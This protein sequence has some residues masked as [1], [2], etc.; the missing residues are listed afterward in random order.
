[1]KDRYLGF[2]VALLFPLLL[3]GCGGNIG[4]PGSTGSSDTGIVVQSVTPIVSTPTSTG[5]AASAATSDPD[6]DTAIHI[7]NSGQPE[8]GLFQTF[9]SLDV[10]TAALN[11]NTTSDPFPGSIEECTITYKKADENP[12]API[13]PQLTVYPNCP[14]LV[15]DNTCLTT[16]M[17]IQ[18]KNDFWNALVGETNYPATYPVHYV[19]VINC[20]YMNAFGKSGT[21]QTEVDVWLADWDL[22]A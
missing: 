10:T 8:D 9:L 22:C 7:C 11:E 5:T 4:S 18:R 16:F 20:T 19:G 14:L 6:I 17:D 2:I 15:G 3:A 21:F 12:D 1:M 13:I